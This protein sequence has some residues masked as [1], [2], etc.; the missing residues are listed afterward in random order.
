MKERDLQNQ[1]AEKFS[2]L[3]LGYLWNNDNGHVRHGNRYKSYGLGVGVSDLIGFTIKDGVP[4]FTAIE[5]KTETGKPSLEQK[6][7]IEFI[8]LSGGLAG[9]AR[10]WEDVLEIIK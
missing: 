2:D 4:V 10:S 8:K 1:I 5:V 7:F 9:I 6:N 3:Q